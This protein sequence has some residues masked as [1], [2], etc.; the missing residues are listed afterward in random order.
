MPTQQP[1]LD[2]EVTKYPTSEV[3]QNLLSSLPPIPVSLRKQLHDAHCHPTDT[4]HTLSQI[5]KANDSL[6]AMST[7]P[8]DQSLVSAFSANNPDVVIPF[9][10]YHPWFAHLFRIDDDGYEEIL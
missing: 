7:C 2:D 10:G 8:N 3:I 5:V 4:P 6:C 9:F 1:L